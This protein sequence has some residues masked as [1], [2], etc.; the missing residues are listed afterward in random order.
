MPTTRLYYS[1]S[2]LTAFDA[3]VTER[4]DDGRRI[5]LDRTAF[6]PTSGGQPH[7]TGRLNGI[8]VTEVVDE[9]DRIAHLLAG[10]LDASHVEGRI[11]W[12]RRHDHMQQHTGQ[13]LLSAVL[14]ERLGHS[15]VSVHFGET[16]STLDLAAAGITLDEVRQVEAWANLAIMENH[17]VTTGTEDSATATGLRKPSE[18]SGLLRIVMIG[19]LDRSACGGTH[20]RST[21][22]I[23]PVLIRKAERMKQ[24]VRLEFL[25][26]VRAVRRA[27]ADFDLLTGMATEASAGL[28]D[29][30]TAVTKL[31]A[32]LKASQGERRELQ[33]QLHAHR[34]RELHQSTVPDARGRRHLV[35]SGSVGGLEDLRG[36]ALAA[37]GLPSTIVTGTA[38][39][40]PTLLLATAADTGLDAGTMLKGVLSAL[41]GRGGGNARLAQ[42]SIP[43]GTDEA[44]ALAAVADALARG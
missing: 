12:A 16:S 18:R 44:V 25:C 14:A 37:I 3:I 15:T 24:Q 35:I 23:G 34:A 42:G 40:P 17:L 33:A 29:L 8:Q 20:V 30:P 5:Y 9:D 43:E 13:H 11:D 2:Y 28:D 26:G 7:D 6:Y 36:L 10:P 41:G 31:R 38:S 19:Q 21:G 4:S 39:N 1:D 22:E 32:E 27:R